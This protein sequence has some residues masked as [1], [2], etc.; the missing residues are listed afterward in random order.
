MLVVGRATSMSMA[1]AGQIFNG[2]AMARTALASLL[3]HEIVS[4]KQRPVAVACASIVTIIPFVGSPIIEVFIQ[5]DIAGQIEGWRVGF[6]IGAFLWV[7]S[8]RT[9]VGALYRPLPRPNATHM[10]TCTTQQL[11]EI[12]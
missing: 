7:L 6:Y 9:F 8:S 2:I 3:L 11:K 4:K 5:K 10:S 12:D 1:I